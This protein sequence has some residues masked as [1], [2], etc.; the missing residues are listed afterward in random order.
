M[1]SW[2]NKIFSSTSLR[3]LL[4]IGGSGVAI[5]AAFS[6]LQIDL[7]GST[8]FRTVL[9]DNGDIHSQLNKRI[10]GRLPTRKD[11]INVS[12]SH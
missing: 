3:R 10:S 9:A 6:L 1:V 8:R 7:N 4:I 11:L 12:F 2:H 5:T